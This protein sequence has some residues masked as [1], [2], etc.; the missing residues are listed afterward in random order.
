M[1][2]EQPTGLALRA[3]TPADTDFIVA[4]RTDPTIAQAEGRDPAPTRAAATAFL[5]RLLAGEAAGT[6][7]TWF[8]IV[9]DRAVGMIGLWGYTADRTRC[10]LAYGLLPAYQGRGLMGQAL[11]TVCAQAFARDPLVALDC[12]TASTNLP[13]RRLLEA[14][15]FTLAETLREPDQ[16]GREV[17][18]VRYQRPRP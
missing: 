10:E 1:T 17:T 8:L 16:T 15:G 2:R 9:D 14:H 11:E 18:M 7:R 4:Y 3:P 5:T 6:S 12:Y 13:S